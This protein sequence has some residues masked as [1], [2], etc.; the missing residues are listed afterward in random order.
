M[1]S[2]MNEDLKF[3]DRVA[4]GDG[5]MTVVICASSHDLLSAPHNG[6]YIAL[7]QSVV[8]IIIISDIEDEREDTVTALRADQRVVIDTG[9]SQFA[10]T[11]LVC[12]S[13]TDR[14]IDGVPRHRSDV[15]N[16]LLYTVTAIDGEQSVV[17]IA[18][19]V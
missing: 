4:A 10:A 16:Q 8:E 3:G 9:L 5:D 7:M 18:F 1:V 15:E 2:G 6:V 17:I 14:T 11:E 12:F 19:L 13:V